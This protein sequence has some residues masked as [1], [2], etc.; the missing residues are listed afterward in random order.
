M[1]SPIGQAVTDHDWRRKFVD[2][3]RAAT[4]QPN[5]RLRSCTDIAGRF[6]WKSCWFLCK[7]VAEKKYSKVI[8]V[9]TIPLRKTLLEHCETRDDDWGRDIQ[10]RLLTCNDLVAEEAI[11]HSTCM[12]RFRL[13]TIT[14]NKK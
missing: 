12:V 7:K 5:K 1:Q 14:S 10:G 4:T 11:Y 8:Q 3:R 2:C 6:D 13:K 9:Q